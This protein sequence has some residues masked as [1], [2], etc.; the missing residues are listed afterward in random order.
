MENSPITLN[1]P[2]HQTMTAEAA[3]GSSDT[4]LKK[5][6]REF[7]SFLYNC[8]LKSMRATVPEDGLFSGGKAESLY[9][10]MLDQEYAQTMSEKMDS[11]LADALY[12]Q[13]MQ[14]QHKIDT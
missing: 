13:L 7:E 10:S 8:M 9:Q 1:S 14:K 3:S 5:Q 4:K 2:L 6:C 12:K 11:S